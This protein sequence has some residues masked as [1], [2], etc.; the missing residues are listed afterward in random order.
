MFWRK[1]LSHFEVRGCSK[2]ESG[3][4]TGPEKS[5]LYLYEI[6]NF[7]NFYL[8][9]FS[10]VNEHLCAHAL[11]VGIPDLNASFL[12]V[13]IDELVAVRDPNAIRT[14]LSATRVLWRR[15]RRL[16]CE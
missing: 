9:F 1:N 3:M 7:R 15:F 8:Y 14:P 16:N 2:F 11:P 12:T 5:Y 13:I 6:L 10:I 4:L